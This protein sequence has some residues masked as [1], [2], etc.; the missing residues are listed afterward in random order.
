MQYGVPLF[1]GENLEKNKLLL[2]RVAEI[3]EEKKCTTS[4]LALAWLMQKDAVQAVPIPGTTKRANLETNVAALGVKLTEEEMKALEE[5][6]PAEE[7]AGSRYTAGTLKS[8]Y[9]TATTPP[10]SSWKG[11]RSLDDLHTWEL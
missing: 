8:T 1:E 5:A 6:V 9:E 4:Q 10:L 7:I 3:A 2:K 11:S